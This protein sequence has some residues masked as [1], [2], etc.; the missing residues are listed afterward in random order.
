MATPTRRHPPVGARAPKNAV[1]VRDSSA[2]PPNLS[3]HIVAADLRQRLE[4][5]HGQ[6]LSQIM[7]FGSQARGD[8]VPGSDIDILVVLE[9]PVDPAEEIA[10]AGEVISELSLKHDV[11]ISCTF[12]SADRYAR[13]RSPLLLNVRR[14]GMPV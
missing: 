9:G 14:E 4:T 2:N 11:V 12:V 3:I 1:A 7:L 10:R 13:E 5:L 8:A 6:R